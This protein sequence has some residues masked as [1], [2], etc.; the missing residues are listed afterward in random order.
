METNNRVDLGPKKSSFGGFNPLDP[1]YQE[2]ERSHAGEGKTFKRAVLV[3]VVA[4]IILF[5]TTFPSSRKPQNVAAGSQKVYVV[6]QVRF[7]P[8]PPKQQTQQIP[9]RKK[10]RIPVP[11]PTP[12]EPE[13]IERE[14]FAETPDLDLPVSD[15]VFTIPEAPAGMGHGDPL[16]V[17][18]D[19]S[20]PVKIHSPQPLY[21]EDARVA[22][23]EGVVILQTI[24]NESGDV[25]DVKVLKGLPHGL[26]E[27]A[28]TTVAEWKFEPARQAGEPVAV[29]YMLTVS[30]SIQ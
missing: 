17:G 16:Q 30:F 25:A 26:T 10:K 18:G 27:S 5:I 4:H 3:A 20:A 13:P 9:D 1:A 19:V 21:S 15:A 28:V 24:V 22:R 23:V 14:E 11:D 8:P 29:Y 6:Q 2:L 12:E 7:K